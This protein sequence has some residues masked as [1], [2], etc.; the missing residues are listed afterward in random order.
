MAG[1]AM[2]NWG[3]EIKVVGQQLF[4]LGLDSLSCWHVFCAVLAGMAIV[5]FT[6]QADKNARQQKRGVIG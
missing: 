2:R 3:Q 5:G 4:L 6:C 1:R